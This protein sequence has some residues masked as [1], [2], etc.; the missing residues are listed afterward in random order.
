MKH[1]WMMILIAT[2][3]CA[4]AEER[5][6]IKTTDGKVY[7]KCKVKRVEPDGIVVFHTGGIGKIL[8]TEM[9]EDIQKKYGYDPEK[10]ANYQKKKNVAMQKFWENNA[11]V[12]AVGKDEP[13]GTSKS[14]AATTGSVP[15]LTRNMTCY[16]SCVIMEASPGGVIV[17]NIKALIK[18]NAKGKKGFANSDGAI[19]HYRKVREEKD[20]ATTEEKQE[21][22]LEQ[23]KEYSFV[24]FKYKTIFISGVKGAAGNTWEGRV[25]AEG[26]HDS[27]LHKFREVH[28]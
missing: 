14:A 21:K 5:I 4:I 3:C 28:L 15:E 13:G 11:A 22:A 8:F 20:S 16:I 27:G 24:P 9:P 26:L 23:F 6:T 1:I 2:A 7:E 10:A 17:G 19:Q 12:K 18:T 25:A